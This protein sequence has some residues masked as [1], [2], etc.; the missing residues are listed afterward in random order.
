MK[1]CLVGPEMVPYAKT[2]GLG[3]VVGALPAALGRL[4]H[5][6]SVFVPMYRDV[7]FGLHRA[8]ALDL[9][10]DVPVGDRTFPATVRVVRQKKHNVM[11]Y[12]V[13]NRHFFDR[14]GFYLD[15]TTG[16][17]YEDNDE[18]YIFF[19]RAVLEILKTLRIQPD[20]IHAHDW[21]AALVPV[22]LKTS[23]ASESLFSG[24]RTV[25]T[26]H[27]LA[28]Q[29]TFPAERFD[30]LGLPGD[31]FAAATGPFE[32][33]GNVNFLKAG[34]VFAD[35]VTTVSRQYAE[36]IQTEEFGAGLDG[37][38]RERTADLV[39]ITNGVDYT[40]WS[41]SR[42]KKI[43]Y[44]YHPANL[45]GKRVNKVE[46]LNIAG[47]PLR[48]K[49]PLIG[50]ISRLVD[51]KGFDLIAETADEIF[52]MD[53]QMVLLGTGDKKYHTLFEDLQQKYPDK[54]RAYLTFDDL[55]AHR[56]EAAAD[57]FLM[58]S[59]F[60]PC[61]LNQ[62]YSLK[63]GTVPIVRRVGGL[64]DSVSDYDPDTKQGTGFVFEEYTAE[65]MLAA[66]RRAVAQYARRRAWTSL[67]KAGMQKDF[68]WQTTAREY[69]DLFESMTTG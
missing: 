13:G 22:Y 35:K 6:V 43:F 52:A 65:A 11:I 15:P 44:N 26:I 66:I 19:N 38:L 48:E 1:V 45:S 24:T 5:E 37:V 31:L 59:Q 53:V 10:V 25:L 34:I 23:Y 14:P 27:N 4:G 67:M 47:L 8:Q 36:E 39:G 60:E 16:R 42:D 20:I 7:S 2:G 18:R 57:I 55:L 30:H 63:Y 64:A 46:L 58:P 61:G 69:V 56:I 41:P 12:F 50:I 29:G 62:L 49:A 51:Q 54:C 33:Y 40:V 28:Y 68:S 9:T 17:D 32:F 3:D 21:Q